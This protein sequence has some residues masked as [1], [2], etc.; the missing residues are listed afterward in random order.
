[1]TDVLDARLD[2][3]AIAVADVDV[4]LA[5]WWKAVGGG[6]VAGESDDAITWV[7]VRMAAGG[8]LELLGPPPGGGGFVPRF[9]D[10]FGPT[11]HHVT[12]KVD[13]LVSAVAT[14]RAAGY[15][16]VDVQ[17]TS[18]WWHEAFLRPSQVG[19]LIVQL[20]WTPEDD[21]ATAARLGITATAPRSSAPRLLGPTLRHPDLDAAA[22]LWT[23]LGA[24]VDRTGPRLV[25]RWPRSALDVVVEAG[26]PA[27]PV[28]LRLAGAVPPV[29][30]V[31]GSPPLDVR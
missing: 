26:Q 11:I 10:R 18:P 29:P 30:D 24:D 27:G 14:V 3:V 31:L 23:L 12:L 7:Q 17:D 8:K 19:G 5:H 28:A 25:C 2:H 4:A 20:A 6:M 13:D 21:A 22:G 16:I 15:D 1:V 9:L